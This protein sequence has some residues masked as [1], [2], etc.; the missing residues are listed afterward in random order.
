MTTE[1]KT[2]TIIPALP[3]W[4]VAYVVWNGKANDG[5]LFETPLIAWEIKRY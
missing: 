5:T 1:T 4:H 2:C 3:G